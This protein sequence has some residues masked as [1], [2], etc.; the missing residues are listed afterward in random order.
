MLCTITYRYLVRALYVVCVVNPKREL[1]V[2][3]N[4]LDTLDTWDRIQRPG[5]LG[6]NAALSLGTLSWAGARFI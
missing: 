1:W 5:A 4:T 3:I 6:L 2:W